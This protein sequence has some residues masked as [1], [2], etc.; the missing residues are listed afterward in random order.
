MT[1]WISVK[2]IFRYLQ[3][4]KSLK[5]FYRSEATLKMEIYTDADYDGSEDRKSTSGF[6]TLINGGA[7]AWGS[8]KQSSV[9]LSTME[10]EY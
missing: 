8:C 5:L 1:D 6:V 2:R 7:V 4:T 10:S 3:G 9:A